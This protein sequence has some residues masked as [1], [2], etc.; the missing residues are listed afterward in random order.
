MYMKF[1]NRHNEKGQ[2]LTELAISTVVIFIILAGVVDLGRM[3]FHYIAMRDAAQEAAS[4]AAIYPTHC[5][6]IRDHALA[7][8]D[9]SPAILVDIQIEGRLLG[10]PSGSAFTNSCS[11]AAGDT[12]KSCFNNAVEITIRDPQFPI[13][14]PFIGTFLGRQTISLQT[15]I[16]DT[17]LRPP[18][19]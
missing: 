5:D 10:L 7:A 11:I 8:L 6:Q 13:T 3:Y 14:M 2:S 18:C 15:S 16:T 12:A 17:I 9:N 4:Y 19:K 1:Q